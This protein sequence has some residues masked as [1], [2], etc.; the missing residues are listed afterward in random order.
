M[1]KR[2]VDS[3]FQTLIRLESRGLSA[4]NPGFEIPLHGTGKPMIRNSAWLL[5]APLFFF[6]CA[7]PDGSLTEGEIPVK[8]AQAD[9]GDSVEAGEPYQI[10]FETT[11]G[12]F[13]IEVYP[14]WAPRGAKHLRELVEDGFYT[15]CSFFR[16]VKGFMVQFG[17]AG[18]PK[19]TKKW[20]QNI[21]D[22]PANMPNKRGYLTFARTGAP[23]SRSTQLFIN[24]VDNNML[25][26]PSQ[27]GFVPLGKVLDDGMSVVD[28]I[29][30]EYGDQQMVSQGAIQEYGNAALVQALP[31]LD[32]IKKATI[33]EKH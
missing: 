4:D 3:F 25:N 14:E 19:M 21:K 13:T 5:L 17:I 23:D 2:F 18:D 7:N 15:D 30:T 16:A 12:N 32:Y 6:G 22:D 8:A 33:V 24:L 9:P 31:N 1:T 28:E 10:L 20:E 29:N 27:R 26:E 11:K